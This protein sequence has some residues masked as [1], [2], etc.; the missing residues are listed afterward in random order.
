[1]YLHMCIC[2]SIYI[3]ID[4][5]YL[6]KSQRWVG[7]RDYSCHMYEWVMSHMWVSYVKYM[8]ESCLMYEWGMSHAKMSHVTR[9]NESCHNTGENRG[10]WWDWEN[11]CSCTWTF[12]PFHWNFFQ[13]YSHNIYYVSVFFLKTLNPI[14]WHGKTVWSQQVDPSPS[15]SQRE[16]NTRQ[17][18]SNTRHSNKGSSTM[19]A[20]Y[21][22]RIEVL[23]EF[24]KYCD[25]RVLINRRRRS[26][27]TV[28]M[29]KKYRSFLTRGYIR[30]FRYHPQEGGHHKQKFVDIG[31]QKKINVLYHKYSST[32]KKVRKFQIIYEHGIYSFDSLIHSETYI[33]LS[34]KI[35]FYFFRTFDF[36][37]IFVFPF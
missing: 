33:F 15:R 26:F 17:R 35:R 24:D 25:P 29:G 6:W 20:W 9:M 2:I 11:T 36:L 34:W 23:I 3:H 28:E 32:Q 31:I 12:A 27:G 14:K 19:I 13:Y 5:W 21:L 22:S 7:L 10:D 30:Y 4:I 16:S 1:M 8:N 37:F 18:E